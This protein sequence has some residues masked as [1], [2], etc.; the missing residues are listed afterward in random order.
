MHNHTTQHA[1]HKPHDD[2]SE[3]IRSGENKFHNKSVG[4][5]D[6][7][8]HLNPNWWK[9]INTITQSVP[10]AK[11]V[12]RTPLS[13]KIVWRGN[14]S[15]FK[16]C[17]KSI[18]GHFRQLGTGCLFNPKFWALHQEHGEDVMEHWTDKS[19]TKEQ[20]LSNN[21]TFFGAIEASC[22]SAEG[23]KELN[24]FQNTQ[25]GI[26]AWIAILNTCDKGGN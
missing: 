7:V 26:K 13:S 11:V 25:D 2:I 5:A 18:T 15:A 9:T 23:E 22:R 16:D 21:E 10:P 14:L 12:K 3:A 4:A 8:D 1:P 20:F 6:P 24:K 19:I 17:K